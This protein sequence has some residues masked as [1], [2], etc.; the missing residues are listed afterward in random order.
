M[1]DAVEEAFQDRDHGI[2]ALDP[3]VREG[4][5]MAVFNNASCGIDEELGRPIARLVAAEMVSGGGAVIGDF[6]EVAGDGASASAGASADRVT[7]GGIQ[8]RLQGRT[9]SFGEPRA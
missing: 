6:V 5:A 9:P 8:F 3:S 2:A 1:V 7:Q 4:E